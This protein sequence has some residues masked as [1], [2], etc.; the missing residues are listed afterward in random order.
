MASERRFRTRRWDQTIVTC[1][2][3]SKL[4]MSQL[5]NDRLFS[6][7]SREKVESECDGWKIRVET[8]IHCGCYG[9][10]VAEGA[11]G[12]TRVSGV[13]VVHQ[14]S[15]NQS[16]LASTQQHEREANR[17]ESRQKPD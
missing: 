16:V 13:C 15:T 4:K 6:S 7:F 10:T 9:V 8:R 2:G 12:T 5:N 11:E 1:D 17:S 3:F 14:L